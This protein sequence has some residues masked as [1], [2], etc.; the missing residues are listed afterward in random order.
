MV[1]IF[2]ENAVA[3]SIDLNMKEDC[4]L[5]GFHIAC[6]NGHLEVVK[7]LMESALNLSIDLHNKT[8]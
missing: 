7:I 4:G 6:G 8:F 3:L 2:L 5:S 1:K